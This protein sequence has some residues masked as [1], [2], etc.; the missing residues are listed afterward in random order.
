MQLLWVDK[1]L[2]NKDKIDSYQLDSSRTTDTISNLTNQ[3]EIPNQKNEIEILDFSPSKYKDNNNEEMLNLLE[4]LKDDKKELKT[5]IITFKKRLSIVLC[6]IYLILF[7]ISIPKIPNRIGEEQKIEALMQNNSNKIINILI[8]HFNFYCNKNINSNNQKEEQ[9]DNCEMTGY[10]LEFSTNKMFI[11]RWSI[12]FLYFVLKCIFF[13][14]SNNKNTNTNNDNIIIKKR[15]NL[16]QKVSMLIFPLSLFYFD[17][18]NNISFSK[19]NLNHPYEKTVS[20]YIMN[21]KRFSFI[22]YVEGLIPTLFTFVI[23]FDYNNIDKII[24]NYVIKTKKLNK[25]V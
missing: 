13:I 15:I 14:Y 6:G 12:G 19:I 4:N 11:F 10:L 20:F 7:L 16:I 2:P 1:S 9:K 3:D 24:N 5:D 21:E 18:Q 23:S 8:N 17:L 25:L 22:D